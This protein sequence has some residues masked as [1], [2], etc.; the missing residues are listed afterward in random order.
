[1][2]N[3]ISDNSCIFFSLVRKNIQVFAKGKSLQT[4]LDEELQQKSLGVLS[5]SDFLVKFWELNPRI[6]DS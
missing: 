6:N 5:T 2:Q 3:N 4:F 1:M